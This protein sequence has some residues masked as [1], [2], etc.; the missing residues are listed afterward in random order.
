M[1]LTVKDVAR[2]C[3]VS[4]KTVYRWLAAGKLPHMRVGEQ[5]RFDSEELRAWAAASGRSLAAVELVA[6]DGEPSE[7]PSL[8]DALAEGGIYYRIGGRDPREVLDELVSIMRLPPQVDRED[9]HRALTAR[10]ELASTG[11]GAGVAIP[12]MRHPLRGLGPAH[13]TL[14][15]LEGP[16]PWGAMDGEDVSVVFCPCCPD[17]R[18]HLHLLA[19]ISFA[20]RDPLWRKLLVAQASRSRLLAGLAELESALPHPSKGGRS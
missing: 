1:D 17:M 10:E 15:F 9:V 3:S 18:S 4:E 13:V 8:R 6:A 5:Y 11:V 2:W 16:V 19:R 12:H 7:L 20:V 14:A